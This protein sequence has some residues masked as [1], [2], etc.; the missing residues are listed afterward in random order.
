MLHP[1]LTALLALALATPPAAA[2]ALATPP[3]TA[4]VRA[5]F[6]PTPSSLSPVTTPASAPTFTP[7]PLPP[8]RPIPLDHLLAARTPEGPAPAPTPAPPTG[9]CHGSR[10]CQRL[11]I[12]SSVTGGLGLATLIAG[13]VVAA[14][15]L[16]IDPGDPTMA[17]AYRPAGTAVL[18]IGIGV[19][20][21]GVLMAIAAARASRQSVRRGSLAHRLRRGLAF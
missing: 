2:P 5:P 1:S 10:S 15:P 17:I 4:P 21:T 18:T 9:L 13:A 16:R 7:R 20:A 11:V 12:L 14:R 8:F 19:L 3:A 6:R